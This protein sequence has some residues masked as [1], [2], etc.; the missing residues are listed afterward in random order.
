[1]AKTKT[2]PKKSEADEMISMKALA[3]NPVLY[4]L[5]AIMGSSGFDMNAST[6]I[7][8]ALTA[9]SALIAQQ[10][11]ELRDTSEAVMEVNGQLHIIN[12]EITAN[13]ADIQEHDLELAD[14]NDELNHMRLQLRDLV[15]VVGNLADDVEDVA[16][17]I[18]LMD[19]EI[20][21]L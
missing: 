20:S 6:Q 3:K 13:R 15:N 19:A 17:A 14:H 5:I 2:K 4:V 12:N 9:Q 11:E 1:M 8:E 10:G 21:E 7:Q 18:S 16:D